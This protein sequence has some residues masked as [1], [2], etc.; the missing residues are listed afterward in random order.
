M[1]STF[2]TILGVVAGICTSSAV[3]P[4]LIKTLKSKKAEDVSP[5]MFI[6][7]LTGNALWIY[8]GVSKK[9]AAIISTNILSFIL[10]AIMLYLNLRYKSDDSKDGD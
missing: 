4:Q 5:V 10:N 9:D 7:T 8:Y 1:D 3:V 6:I 2:L